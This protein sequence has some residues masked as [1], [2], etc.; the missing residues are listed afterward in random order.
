[1]KYYSY[2]MAV[3]SIGENRQTGNLAMG[4]T[5]AATELEAEA[6][7][8]AEARDSETEIRFFEPG[9]ACTA[10]PTGVFAKEMEAARLHPSRCVISRFSGTPIGPDN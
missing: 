2:S 10:T 8:I 7:V 1:M 3:R 6:N 5:Y 4:L 9:Y